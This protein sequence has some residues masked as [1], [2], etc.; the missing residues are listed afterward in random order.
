VDAVAVL[1]E[2]P[3]PAAYWRKLKQRLREEGRFNL[4]LAGIGKERLEQ[5]QDPEKSIKQVMLDR[6]LDDLEFDNWKSQIVISN[7]DKMGLER[8]G[9]KF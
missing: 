9:L 3:D 6:D 2:S 7:D 8:E 4:W 1:T 5:A